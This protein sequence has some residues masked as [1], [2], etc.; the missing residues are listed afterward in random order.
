M[1]DDANEDKELTVENLKEA[2]QLWFKSIQ[3]SSF[4]E[5]F[6]ILNSS[7]KSPGQLINQLN[8]FLDVS[9][10]IRCKGRLEFSNI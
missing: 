3:L 6:R 7:H 1:K 5:E 4:P 10:I 8:L 9:K 2:E